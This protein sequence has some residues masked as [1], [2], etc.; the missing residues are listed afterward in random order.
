M[1]IKVIFEDNH[2]IAV[3]KPAGLLSDPGK[4]NSPSLFFEVK[5]YLKKKYN[6]PGNVFLGI[7]H[8]LD[9]PVS[10]IMLFGKTSKGASRLSEQI[11]RGEIKKT[12]TALVSGI[13]KEKK[14][15]LK[16]YLLKDRIKNKTS[17]FSSLVPGGKFSELSY[18]VIKEGKNCSLLTI[19]LKTGRSHQIRASLSSLGHP[20]F[21][22]QKYGSKEK[23]PDNSIALSASAVEFKTA[24]TGEIIK[25]SVPASFL[26]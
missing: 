16:N 18:E 20:I 9:R 19:I 8:R 7:V 5:K 13:L 4:D 6:K 2:V 15:S 14:G 10:G 1:K 11:R 21:G 17:V 3:F 25:L 12:Y 22:D 24:T 26:L 23:M